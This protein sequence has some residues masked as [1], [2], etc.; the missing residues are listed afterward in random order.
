MVYNGWIWLIPLKKDLISIGVVIPVEE[1]QKAEKSPQAFLEQYMATTPIVPASITPKPRLE[2]KVHIYGNM[3]H[4]TT[5]AHGE[6]W[7]LVGDAAFFID[8]C[9]SSG[10]HMALSMAK[11]AAHLF[12]ESRRSGKKQSE[13]F[14]GYG[15]I[16]ARREAGASLCRCL[17]HAVSKELVLNGWVIPA[18]TTEGI[19]RSFVGVTGGDFT[20]HPVM[21]GFLISCRKLSAFYFLFEHVSRFWK[22]DL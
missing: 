11:E 19:N 21:I 5:Q 8:P 20:R 17:L 7:A 3:G 22:S 13:L 12:L 18:T 2:G 14:V 1:Y 6:G 16:A 15:S 10:V 4:T 9:Y